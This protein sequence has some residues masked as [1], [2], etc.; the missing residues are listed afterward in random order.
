LPL[1][2]AL[3]NAANDLMSKA[4]IDNSDA[5]I[6][7]VI[8]PLIDGVTGAQSL[9]THWE[10]QRILELIKSRYPRFK[11]VPFT[12][13]SIAKRPL[14]LIG[15]FTPINNDGSPAG[16]RDAYRICLAFA[17]LKSRTI[18]SK[19]VARAQP[20][21]VDPTPLAFFNDSPGF[22]KDAATDA[23]VKSCQGSKPGDRVDQTYTDDVAAAALVNEG[24][25][26]YNAGRYEAAL[27]LYQKAQA[28]PGGDQ[29]RVY[30]GIY[31]AG[32]KLHRTKTAMDA[33][34]RMI[35]F[36]LKRSDNLA[37]KFLFKPGSTQFYYEPEMRAP[38]DAWIGKIAQRAAASNRGCLE[39]VGH[40]SATGLP[41]VNERLSVLRADYIKDRV[42]AEKSMLRGRLL[43]EGRGSREMIVGTGRDDQSDALDRRVEFKVMPCGT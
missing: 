36:G 6:D 33:F 8:D 39:V 12:L 23:Y 5:T 18:V 43:A 31:L 40:T 28:M 9:A 1:E 29:M 15:T 7:L 37:I 24:I 3:L 19:G 41:A 21:G 2:T 10:Q 16:A 35:D 34:G 38:Y 14:V 32:Y 11:V 22:A 30:N 27:E 13:E 26:A 17:D 25:E 42:E 4:T 20:E